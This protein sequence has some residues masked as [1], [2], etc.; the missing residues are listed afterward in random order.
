VTEREGAAGIPEG[1][2]VVTLAYMDY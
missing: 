2:R 1:R